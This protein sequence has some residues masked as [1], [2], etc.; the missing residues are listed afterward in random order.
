MYSAY[1][2]NKQGDNIQPWRTPFLIW[3]PFVVPCPVLT[4]VS[5]PAYRFLRRQVRW[6]GIPISLSIFHSLLWSTQPKQR[7]VCYY[8]N[9]STRV[10]CLFSHVRLFMTLR[11]VALQA[12]LSMG[13]FRQ[14][15]WSGLPRPPPRDLWTQGSNLVSYVFCIGRQVLYHYRHLE[16]PYYHNR[17]HSI[18]LS[19]FFLNEK[20]KSMIYLSSS[21]KRFYS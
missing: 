5:W 7:H 2:L 1:K 13:F 18:L 14:E 19:G 9:A 10:C 16:S 4:V 8:H 11:T 3:N 17:T 15:Y 21:G 12:P 6:S 20:E